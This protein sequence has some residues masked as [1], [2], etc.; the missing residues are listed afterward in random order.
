MGRA[1]RRAGPHHPPGLSAARAARAPGRDRVGRD[2][3][4]VRAHVRLVRLQGH[5]DREPPAGAAEQGR[6]GGRRPRG[7]AAPPGR[8]ACSRGPGPSGIER[9]RRTA[10]RSAATTAGWPG[11]ATPCWPSAPSRTPTASASST[12]ASLVD[13]G[14]LRADQPPLPVQ[15]GPHLRRRR[16]VGQA[17]AVVGG[18]H[19]GPQDR[20]ARHGPAHPGAPPPRLRQGGVGHLH[21]ARDRRRRAW[22]RPRPSPPGARSG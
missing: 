7:R 20:R 1:R 4:R 22:P 15:R 12:P 6:R 13:R 3:R 5:P 2:R 14:R 8:H 9:D 19:A 16:R 21:R 18:V 11:V 10:C 17:A